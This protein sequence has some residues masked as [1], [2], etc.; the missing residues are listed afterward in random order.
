LKEQDIK[1]QKA[2]YRSLLAK[3]RNEWTAGQKQLW[4]SAAC[5][6][7]AQWLEERRIHTFMVYA[8]FRSELDLREL[9]EWGWQ[10]GKDVIIP[11]CV[12][13]DK[14][15]TLHHLRGWDELIPGAYGIME[16]NPAATLPIEDSFVPEAIFVPGLAFDRN[17][18]RIGYGGGYYDRFAQA[19]RS[20]TEHAGQPLWVGVGY[21][22]Q[23]A[24]DIPLEQHDLRMDCIVTE[25]QLYD[26]NRLVGRSTANGYDAF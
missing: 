21:E 14:S 19:V 23:L 9:I 26:V 8:A 25:Q 7:A 2:A 17:G 6:H 11:R 3:Q 20:R 24:E 15:M 22:T 13:A 16:P 1:A 12:A 10:A 18:G 4:S 5:K